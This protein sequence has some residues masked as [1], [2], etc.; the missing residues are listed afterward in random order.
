MR[1]TAVDVALK[2]AKAIGKT[3]STGA[4]LV[5]VDNIGRDVILSR[6]SLEHG[7]DRRFQKIFLLH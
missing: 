3:D 6:K 7:F 4:V 1:K 5:H 2:N